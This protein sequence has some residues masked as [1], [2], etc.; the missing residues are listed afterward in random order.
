[1]QVAADIPPPARIG[2]HCQLDETAAD[3]SWLG[4]GPHENYPDRKLAARQGRW[5]LPLSELF[6][7]YVFPS[8]NG[9]RCDTRELHYGV[10]HLQGAFHF[11]LSRYSQRQLHD[12]THRHRLRE[13]PGTWLNLDA[14]HMGVG[15]DDSWSPSVSPEFLLPQRRV[16]YAFSWRQD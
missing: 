15:G 4:L 12:T 8:E 3:V 1:M 7:P 10:H 16:H 6:T 11:G 9:L 14:F 13:E 2:L 5:T